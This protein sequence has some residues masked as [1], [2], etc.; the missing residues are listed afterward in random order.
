MLS[1]TRLKFLEQIGQALADQ[2]GENCEIVVHDV[3]AVQKYSYIAVL[4]NGHITA[5][6]LG[7][8]PSHIVLEAM[9]TPADELHD[10]TSY[11]T[12]THEGRILKSSTLYLKNDEGE[13]DGVLSINFDITSLL[14]VEGAIASLT[15][16]KEEEK[17]QDPH[18]IPRSVN[19]L[20][21]ELIEESVRVVGKPVA[22]MNKEDKIKAV[23]FLEK[24]GAMLI[25][26]SGDKISKFFNISKYTLYSYI[27][28][29]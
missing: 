16:V 24:H 25:T 17:A 1:K 5:R 3:D 13:L 6:H 14:T 12:R 18:V 7:D 23:Q 11:L 28:A 4:I 21:D 9:N 8:G 26:K 27:D 19:D 15:S 22:L 2:F 10:E 20:L 29:K